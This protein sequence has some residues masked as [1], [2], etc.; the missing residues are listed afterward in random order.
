MVTYARHCGIV[1]LKRSLCKR[2][3]AQPMAAWESKWVDACVCASPASR[4][5]SGCILLMAYA[6]GRKRLNDMVEHM[7]ERIAGK[8]G[9]DNANAFKLRRLCMMYDTK[10]SGMV[11][12]L[13]PP[14]FI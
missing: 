3:T 13:P 7:R 1:S 10:K 4:T 5:T 8:I 2:S 11:G 12:N 14:F 9:N 6:N